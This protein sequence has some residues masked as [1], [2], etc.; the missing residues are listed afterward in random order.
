MKWLFPYLENQ[1]NFGKGGSN[2]TFGGEG[3]VGISEESKEKN[4][5][6]RKINMGR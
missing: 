5:K 2:F 3:C 6:L 4:K 1:L